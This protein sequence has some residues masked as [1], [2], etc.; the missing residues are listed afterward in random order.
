[1]LRAPT[2]SISAYSQIKSTSSVLIT[3][4]TT[5]RPVRSRANVSRLAMMRPRVSSNQTWS[6]IAAIA[7]AV[8]GRDERR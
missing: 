8:I 7:P 1:M 3:S 5:G 4:V 6:L 2:C